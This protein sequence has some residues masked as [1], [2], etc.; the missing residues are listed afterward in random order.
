MNSKDNSE[1]KN[2]YLFLSSLF[3]SPPNKEL[4][5]KAKEIGEELKIEELKNSE[6]NLI[7]LEIEFHNLFV[8]PNE[9]YVRPFESVYVDGMMGQKTMIKVKKFYEEQGIKSYGIA[10][11][12][13]VELQFMALLCDKDKELQKKFFNEHLINWIS[14]LCDEIIKSAEGNFYKGVAILTKNFLDFER[15]ELNEIKDNS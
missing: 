9:K 1:R 10:D 3:L 4:V 7:K 15:R 12:V 8:V 13:G 6:D 11:N 2:T 14:N 5:E